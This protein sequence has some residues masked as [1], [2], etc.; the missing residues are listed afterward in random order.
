[1]SKLSN[2]NKNSTLENL[3]NILKRILSAK[4]Y[5]LLKRTHSKIKFFKFSKPFFK[6]IR[7]RDIDF[8]LYI[9]R[10]NGIVDK[11]IY[12]TPHGVYEEKNSIEILKNLKEN[13]I[14][15]DVGANIG[16]Y[17]NLCGKYLIKGGV[18]AF[19]PIKEIYLQNLKSIRKNKLINI[20]LH[21]VGCG[22]INETKNIYINKDN[23]GGSSIIEKKQVIENNICWHDRVEEIKVVNLDS[24]LKNKKI[25]FVKIDVEGFEYE[26][27][28]GMKMIIKNHHPKI[29]IEFSSY[30]YES[31][32]KGLSEKIIELLFKN[33]K[34]IKI[35]DTDEEYFDKRMLLKKILG[36]QVN[37]ICY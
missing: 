9:N 5:T 8:Y 1:M 6:R 22:M 14:F 33:Y 31:L 11:Q 7:V 12:L 21:N 36:K 23:V 16:Y 25:D 24:F 32:E 17:T 3:T 35:I 37:I 34:T 27:L 29:L 13:D 2:N 26:V 20:K 4:N 30:I 15:L 28:K 18:I 10:N 19:E